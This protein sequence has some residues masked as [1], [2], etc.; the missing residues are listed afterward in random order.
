MYPPSPSFHEEKEKATISL[1]LFKHG[2]H[3]KDI[4]ETHMYIGWW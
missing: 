4:V 1:S 2:Q 3:K